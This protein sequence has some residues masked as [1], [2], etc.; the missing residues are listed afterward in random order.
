MVAGLSAAAFALTH[1]AKRTHIGSLGSRNPVP[2]RGLVVLVGLAGVAWGDVSAQQTP[3][4]DELA[5]QDAVG[6][7]SVGGQG[8]SP[9]RAQGWLTVSAGV[10]AGPEL[11]P[12][13]TPPRVSARGVVSGWTASLAR[14]MKGPFH[15]RPGALGEAL[16]SNN[17]AVSAIG[18]SAPLGAAD[19][20]G[21]LTGPFG[22]GGDQT[23]LA[24]ETRGAVGLMQ[25]QITT[26]RV[27]AGVILLDIADGGA[28]KQSVREQDQRL[29]V[30]LKSL[31]PTAS[32]IVASLSDP[33]P[34]H[35]LRLIAVKDSA[36]HRGGLLTS[37]S[38]RRPGLTLLADVSATVL[39]DLD[40]ASPTDFTGQPLASISGSG[41][42]LQQ[43]QVDDVAATTV[44]ATVPWF[45]AVLVAVGLLILGGVRWTQ[46][47]SN[48]IAL[49]RQQP[50]PRAAWMR[51]AGQ[52]CALVAAS[53]PV[54]CYLVNL[55]P[56]QTTPTP[57][58]VSVAS[59]AA[60]ALAL[61]VVAV[62]APGALTRLIRSAPSAL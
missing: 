45:F 12:C 6:N 38:T 46:R 32:V 18:G 14:A 56:W 58:L 2:V 33:G 52:M 31:P 25:A 7:L 10:V 36:T 34:T 44:D 54:S 49:D 21:R 41:P 48:D 15:A 27:R 60:W 57:A 9:C 22:I 4:L 29:G 24:R 5:H 59:A 37:R 47:R 23:G 19:A 26:G 61:G 13:Q 40:M 35:H 43:L 28:H 42:S 39:A 3:I 50:R 1:S 62:P 17:V 51:R 53:V 16:Q 20:Q 11:R 8:S 30:V 55:V